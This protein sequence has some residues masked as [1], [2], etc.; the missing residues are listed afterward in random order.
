[1]ATWLG[2]QFTYTMHKPVCYQLKTNR[3]FAEDIDYEWQADLAD[4]GSVGSQALHQ[5][6]REQTVKKQ[7]S[8]H[9]PMPFSLIICK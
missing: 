9:F 6:L 8:T 1:M 5:S 7:I 4:L 2:K 3:V